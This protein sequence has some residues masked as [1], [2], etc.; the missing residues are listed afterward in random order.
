LALWA[1]GEYFAE[2]RDTAWLNTPAAHGTVYETARDCVV[3]P[4]VANLKPIGG[5]GGRIFRKDSSCWEQNGIRR[6]HYAFSN[7]TAIGGLNAFLPVAEAMSDLPTVASIQKTIHQMRAGF[8]T[9][10]VHGDEVCGTKEPGRRNAMD[11]ALLEGINFA[12]ITN[13]NQIE[14]TLSRMSELETDSGGYRRV[15]GITEEY[16]AHEFLFINFNLARAHIRLGNPA[17]ADALVE[18]MQHKAAGDNNLIP[19]MYVSRLTVSLPERSLARSAR[20]AGVRLVA[21]L[22]R[23]K[24]KH[25]L[26]RFP[27]PTLP[28]FARSRVALG[29]TAFAA[30]G[31]F[32]L[33]VCHD[34]ATVHY[35]PQETCRRCL[36]GQ[37]EWCAQDGAGELLSDTLLHHS[38]EPYFRA[39]LPLR[40]GSVQLDVGPTAVAFVHAACPAPP[41]RVRVHAALNRAGAAVLVALPS[42][43]VTTLADDGVLRELID[44]GQ[45]AAST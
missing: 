24:R 10:F 35:P 42:G 41:A 26:R 20:S 5:K 17:T 30:Q 2:Y 37:L 6:Q 36:S 15:L 23:P 22:T 29:L 3:K 45:V 43:E 4:L 9:A 27:S 40:V 21:T 18:R 39:H 33:Q 13:P 28:P 8:Q 1:T 12:V 16:E 44:E 14:S 32:A 19:E 34:C 11:G 25:P 31:R 7:I 38:N